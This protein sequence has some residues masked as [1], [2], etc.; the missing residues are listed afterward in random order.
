MG[1]LARTDNEL[2]FHEFVKKLALDKKLKQ[3]L[4]Q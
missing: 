3:L 1:Q 4:H 2:A